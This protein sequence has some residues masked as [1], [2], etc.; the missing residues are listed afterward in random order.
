M[1]ELNLQNLSDKK[2]IYSGVYMITFPN[3]KKYIGISNNIRRRMI[4]H[5]QDFRNNLP[6]EN[7]IKKYGK[8]EK[9]ILLEEIAAEDRQ[10]MREQEKYWI[11]KYHS[12]L[13]EF[14]Y[15][16]S[17]GGDGADIGSNNSQA[18]FTEEQIQQIYKELRECKITMTEIAAKYDIDL[19]SLSYINNGKTY[20]HSS[21]IYPIRYGFQ[22]IKKGIQNSNSKFSEE[23]LNNIVSLLKENNISIK[24]I[25]LKYSV[26]E[27]TI[28]KIN[29]GKTYIRENEEYP[30]RISKVGS[31]KLTDLQ[32]KEIF[33][34][35][36]N[37]PE[38]RLYQIAHLY[39]VSA[40][41]ISAINCGT[42]YKSEEEIYPIRKKQ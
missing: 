7:A 13:K 27:S 40:K 26:A 14:G 32:V 10:I 25:A 4:E 19:S 17:E 20:F 29:K 18:K 6:I 39:G 36:K 35:L 2:Y 24:E 1:K 41:T 30:L 23:D 31:K 42:I 8:I 11:A 34:L 3:N 15:N 22:K 38:L 37:K 16:V 33:S 9:F 21:E 12:N 5:N 28:Q